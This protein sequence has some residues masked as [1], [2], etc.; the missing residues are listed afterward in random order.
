MSE[1]LLYADFG[2]GVLHHFGWFDEGPL[3]VARCQSPE[4]WLRPERLQLDY[5]APD[6]ADVC[7]WCEAGEVHK[8]PPAPR[9]ATSRVHRRPGTVDAAPLREAFERSGLSYSEVC[10]RADITRETVVGGRRLVVTETSRLQRMLGIRP[11]FKRG[12]V[13]RYQ[14][15]LTKENA[16]KIVAALNLDPVDFDL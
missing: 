7:G 13:D 6:G 9:G 10:R 11:G 3:M 8:P 14:R 1:P 4:P 5:Q 2:D 15:G 12:Q 16:A